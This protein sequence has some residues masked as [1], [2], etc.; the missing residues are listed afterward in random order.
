MI[1][2][3]IV[4]INKKKLYIIYYLLIRYNSKSLALKKNTQLIRFFSC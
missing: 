4:S 2:E 1:R 3:E